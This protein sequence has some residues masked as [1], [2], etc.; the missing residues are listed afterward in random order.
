MLKNDKVRAISDEDLSGVNGGMYMGSVL[1]SS[2]NKT[3]Y[4]EAEALRQSGTNAQFDGNRGTLT[5]LTVRSGE[6]LPPGTK[7]VSGDPFSGKC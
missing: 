5:D 3:V 2:G 6:V 1:S 4:N 7:V